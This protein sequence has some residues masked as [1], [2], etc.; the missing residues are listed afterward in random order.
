MKQNV[1]TVRKNENM[2]N[3]TLI[4]KLIQNQTDAYSIPSQADLLAQLLLLIEGGDYENLEQWYHW[5]MHR[6]A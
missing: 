1:I 5:I 3:L 2:T 4:Q 6:H